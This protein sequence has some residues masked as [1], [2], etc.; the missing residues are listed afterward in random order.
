MA[1]LKVEEFEPDHV[2]AK[3]WETANGD[4][5]LVICCGGGQ[6]AAPADIRAKKNQVETAILTKH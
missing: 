2:I 1:V 3:L 5:E 6:S 4:P